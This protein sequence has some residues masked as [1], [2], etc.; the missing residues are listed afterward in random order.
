MSNSPNDV[1]TKAKQFVK[2]WENETREQAEAKTFWNEFFEVFGR[3]RRRI[4]DFEFRV[5]KL[6]HK[7]GFIDLLWKGV[8]LV[9]HKSKGKNLDRA[10]NQAAD[11]FPGLK[12]EELPRFIL[13]S[14]FA[15]FRLYDLDNGVHHDFTLKELP[16]KTELFN[17]ILEV[18]QE[19]LEK[20]VKANTDAANAMGRLHDKLKKTGYQSPELDLYLSDCCFVYLLIIL[21]FLKAG[22]ESIFSTISS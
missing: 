20:D 13:V 15:R 11:Y 10:F 19:V 14:D 9:E 1:I 6:G 7:V 12:E 18:E 3:S 16:D 8:L 17:F 22:I 2:D 5:E 21:A 4:A